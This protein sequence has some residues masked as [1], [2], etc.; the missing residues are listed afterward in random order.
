GDHRHDVEPR[1]R[2]AARA[3]PRVE[4]LTEHL[5]SPRREERRDPAVGDLRGERRV[6]GADRREIDREVR[7]PVQDR[8]ER[9]AEA[10]RVRARVR[11]L[12]VLAPELEP[13]LPTADAAHDL[14]VLAR[15]PHQ[16]AAGPPVP[17]R[18]DLPPRGTARAGE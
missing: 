11:D 9:L 3:E 10:R 13:L 5:D 17:T 4:P 16:L 7:A 14:D 1:G 6:P 18:P 15:P 8:F 12:I 2:P